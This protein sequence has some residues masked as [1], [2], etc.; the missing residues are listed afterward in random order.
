MGDAWLP[1]GAVRVLAAGWGVVGDSVCGAGA[2]ACGGRWIVA[3]A[4]CSEYAAPLRPARSLRAAGD[5]AMGGRG[6]FFNGWGERVGTCGGRCE[7]KRT[8]VGL[9]GAGDGG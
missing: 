9:C 3:C 4:L 8:R 5:L 7:D 1:G 6:P 2:P